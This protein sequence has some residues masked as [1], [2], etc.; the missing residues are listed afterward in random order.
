MRRAAQTLK[1]NCT[2]TEMDLSDNNFGPEGASKLARMLEENNTLTS[3]DF[4]C[5]LSLHFLLGGALKK[6]LYTISKLVNDVGTKGAKRLAKALQRNTS[7]TALKMT[8]R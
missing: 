5:S 6:D 7:L 2:L 4:S 8:C 1:S 3:L